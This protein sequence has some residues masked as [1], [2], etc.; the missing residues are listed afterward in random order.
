[1]CDGCIFIKKKTYCMLFD[2]KNNGKVEAWWCKVRAPET[3]EET[4]QSIKNIIEEFYD[5][6]KKDDEYYEYSYDIIESIYDW[7]NYQTNKEM[8]NKQI[9]DVLKRRTEEYLKGVLK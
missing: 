7:I 5:D 4:I 6:C 1:M 9:E 8:L 3:A 2:K